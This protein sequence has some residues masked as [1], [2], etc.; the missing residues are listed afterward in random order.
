MPTPGM[1]W[2]GLA[3]RCDVSP[4][5]SSTSSAASPTLIGGVNGAVAGIG[6]GIHE[7]PG[8]S[9][10]RRRAIAAREPRYPEAIS[11]WE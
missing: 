7:Q 1:R 2:V 6:T 4:A 10:L 11:G 8:S 9:F 5:S 3:L